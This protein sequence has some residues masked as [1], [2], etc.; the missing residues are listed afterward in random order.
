MINSLSIVSN[1]SFSIYI[2]KQSFNHWFVGVNWLLSKKF[3]IKKK[4]IKSFW[5]A[6]G[7]MAPHQLLGRVGHDSNCLIILWVFIFYCD[8]TKCFNYRTC[9]CLSCPYTENWVS[10]ESCCAS[11][12]SILPYFFSSWIASGIQ[13][14][15]TFIYVQR[16]M[17]MLT[18]LYQCCRFSI[19]TQCLFMQRHKA[20]FAQKL[21]LGDF[22]L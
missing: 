13:V 19:C 6:D 7:E 22:N 18:L 5:Q 21:L 10:I 8:C 12:Y 2:I 4:K 15:E 11:Y 17:G 20:L 1:T 3:T 16:V 9:T 14:F